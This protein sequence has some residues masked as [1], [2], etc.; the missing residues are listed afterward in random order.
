[1]GEAESREREFWVLLG[2][3]L[4][5]DICSPNHEDADG[6]EGVSQQ[7]Q[8]V[9]RHRG[10]DQRTPCL[11]V[12]PMAPLPTPGMSPYLVIL[13]RTTSGAQTRG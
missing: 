6:F 13:E 12:L 7:G 11:L 10:E 8:W 1:M 5:W 9:P 4:G 3:N 2:E